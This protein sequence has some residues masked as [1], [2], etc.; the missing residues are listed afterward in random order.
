MLANCHNPELNKNGQFLGLENAKTGTANF[1][2]RYQ[3]NAEN[4]PFLSH[5]SAN[6]GETFLAGYKTM[7]RLL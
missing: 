6:H 1:Q 4:Q 5:K 3:I 7:L 2:G